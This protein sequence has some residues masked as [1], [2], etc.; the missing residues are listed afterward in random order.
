MHQRF[1]PALCK[2]DPGGPCDATDDCTGE[3]VCDAVTGKC[4]ESS[5]YTFVSM[6]IPVLVWIIVGMR[7]AR[8]IH[9]HPLQSRRW[10]RLWREW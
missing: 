1:I 9:S 2:S 10:R 3:L 6:E 8:V 7:H 4:T 5:C